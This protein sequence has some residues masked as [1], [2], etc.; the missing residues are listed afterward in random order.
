MTVDLERI[1]GLPALIYPYPDMTRLCHNRDMSEPADSYMAFT[2]HPTD[3]GDDAFHVRVHWARVGG[4]MRVVGLDLRS[5]HTQGEGAALREFMESAEPVP[6]QEPWHDLRTTVLRGLRFSEVVE[7]SRTELLARLK[8]TQAAGTPRAQAH[9]EEVGTALE[10]GKRRPGP[11][12]TITDEHLEQI[13]AP[14]YMDAGPHQ[15]VEKVRQA[16]V[17]ARIR[18]L[19]RHVTKEQAKK[20]IQRARKAGLIPAYNRRNK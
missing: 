15:P 20:A 8:G 3:I 19:G 10:E 6:L 1:R 2:E 14:A 11:A 17:A 7:E 16:L 18:G 5:F 4:Q 12:A 9:R 13:V